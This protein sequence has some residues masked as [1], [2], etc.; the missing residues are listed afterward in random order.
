MLSAQHSHKKSEKAVIRFCICLRAA[1]AIFNIVI[2]SSWFTV[3]TTWFWFTLTGALYLYVK[4]RFT[5]KLDCGILNRIA[6]KRPFNG[7]NV[8]RYARKENSRCNHSG[9]LSDEKLQDFRPAG[10][11]THPVERIIVINTDESGFPK[12]LRWPANMEV[13]HIAPEEFDHGATRDMAARKS[14]ADLM[15]FMTQDAVPADTHLV[16]YLAK[17]F[18]DPLVAAAYARQLAKKTDS[19]I[20]RF[21]RNFNYPAESRVKTQADIQALG[22]KTYF[23]SNSCAMYR[24]STYEELGGFLPEAIFNEDMVFASTAINAGYSVAY[25]AEARVI[26]SHNYTGFQQFQRNFDN[27]VSHADNQETFHNVETL[28]EGKRLVFDTARYLIRHHEFGQLFR[29]VYISGCKV[30]GYKLGE[31]YYK[32]PK[33]LISF[34]TMNKKYWQE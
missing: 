7:G 25:V 16:E 18:D 30:V 19:A 17:A 28:G 24:K 12:N 33:K 15:L 23:C 14:T 29:L 20:E 13:Y 4:S 10:K 1:C 2:F 9:E 5:K 21:T 32:L 11:Q 22:I 27:G 26:H 8:G 3:P 6:D 34:C 31:K